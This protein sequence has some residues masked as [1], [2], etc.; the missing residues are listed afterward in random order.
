M[1][2]DESR[3]QLCPDDHRKRVWRRPGQRGDPA[4]P[5]AR[6]KDPQPGVRRPIEKKN[7]DFDQSLEREQKPSVEETRRHFRKLRSACVEVG[8]I[9][10]YSACVEV[11]TIDKYSACVEVGTHRQ[12]FRLCRG[13]NHSHKHLRRGV[14]SNNFN[15]ITCE[16]V[17][18]VESKFFFNYWIHRTCEQQES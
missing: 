11:G 8:T 15:Y 6:H 18:S 14:N 9:D 12:K 7:S 16:E 4:F 10:K 13:W 2:S 17:K 1:F 3:F 5:I